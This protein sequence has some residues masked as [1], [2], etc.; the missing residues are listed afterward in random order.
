MNKI[1]T[2]LFIS[3]FFL[4]S[5]FAQQ[6]VGVGTTTPD[7]SAILHAESTSKGMLVPRMSTAQRLAIVSPANGLLVYD[8]TVD[9]FFYYVVATANWQSLCAGSGNSGTNALVATATEP[10][11]VNCA[12]GGIVITSG[13]DTDND[14]VLD[15]NEISST[16]YVCNGAAGAQ[17][18]TGTQGPAGPTGTQ[19]PAGPTGT[20]GPAGPT[21]A[22]GPAGATGP[23]G[24]PGVATFYSAVG[25]T[26]AS[27]TT[28]YP[29]FV[30]FPQMTVTFTPTKPT[31]YVMFSAAGDALATLGAQQYVNFRLRRNGT[32]LGG[33]TSVTT[34][35]DDVAGVVTAWN[36][37]IILPVTV[38][39]GVSTTI[40]IQWN[41]DGLQTAQTFCNAATDINWSHRSLVIME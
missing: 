4:H 21:G 14:G 11:G 5:T 25:T 28:L 16:Q 12:N 27:T 7:A 2:S 39:P 9:C 35:V 17:G 22:Q 33:T 19:G 10:A 36:A 13:S 26:D 41:I 37:Q 29:T 31:V 32:V 24:L 34:D 1:I 15:L 20:Q 3:I 23:Q 38:T 18:P 40:D 30:A 6:N 8:N